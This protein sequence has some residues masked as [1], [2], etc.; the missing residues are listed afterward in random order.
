MWTTKHKGE[1]MKLYKTM[2]RE[3]F[4]VQDIPSMEMGDVFEFDLKDW[5]VVGGVPNAAYDSKT[6]RTANIP[7]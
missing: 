6:G 3:D 5:L 4:Q 1:N 2:T 7:E